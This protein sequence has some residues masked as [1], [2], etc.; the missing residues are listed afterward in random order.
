MGEEVGGLLREKREVRKEIMV[1]RALVEVDARL[2]RRGGRRPVAAEVA[3]CVVLEL[4]LDLL[5]TGQ[6]LQTR[7]SAFV[8]QGL[9]RGLARRIQL[10]AVD[11]VRRQAPH[12]VKLVLAGQL[13]LAAAD[14]AVQ[15]V[16]F[17]V[18]DYMAIH[19]DLVQVA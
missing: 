7:G 11:F 16:A 4:A 12:R 13:P 19:Q 9:C 8:K 15:G 17:D 10:V 5:A 1:G 2:P 18:R 14:L 3:A 6:V